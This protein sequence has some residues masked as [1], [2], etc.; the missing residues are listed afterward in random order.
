MDANKRLK[1]KEE[2]LELKA[3]EDI[4]QRY[5]AAP[6]GVP[7]N[8]R[9]PHLLLNGIAQIRSVETGEIIRE[10]Q[11]TRIEFSNGSSIQGISPV[12]EPEEHLPNPLIHSY[13]FV[14]NEEDLAR[15]ANISRDP[16]FLIHV[17]Y[18][19]AGS[20]AGIE[21]Q[22]CV[23]INTSSCWNIEC[24]LTDFYNDTENEMIRRICQRHN[25]SELME[26]MYEW[27]WDFDHTFTPEQ[28]CRMLFINLMNEPSISWSREFT[29]Y[30]L[31][32]WADD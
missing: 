10:T 4:R 24:C 16:M 18:Y 22:V 6:P 32:E 9:R 28:K 26:S 3:L 11:P 13:D 23:F 14:P 15:H 7:L 21:D 5:S 31:E 17:R 30:M 27:D 1:S 25:L 19:P 2:V 29:E 12:Y 20:N 8:Q